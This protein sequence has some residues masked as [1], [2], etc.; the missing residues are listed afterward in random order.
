[1]LD[2]ISKDILVGTQIYWIRLTFL[3]VLSLSRVDLCGIEFLVI[4]SGSSRFEFC[5]RRP[6]LRVF[7]PSTI[8]VFRAVHSYN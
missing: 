4:Y 3:D 7:C 8:M 1:M 2:E 5:R 6:Q